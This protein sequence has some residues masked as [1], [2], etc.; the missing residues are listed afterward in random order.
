MLGG[1]VR[2]MLC[3]TTDWLVLGG[4][5]RYMRWVTID[6]LVL[7]GLVWCMRCVTTGLL[8]ARWVGPMYAL[9]NY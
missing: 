7:G 5:V 3:V 2:C 1:L 8:S 4:L 6:W 9:C